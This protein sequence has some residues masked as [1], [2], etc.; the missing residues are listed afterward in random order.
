MSHFEATI[1]SE[2]EKTKAALKQ[3]KER[4]DIVSIQSRERK[5]LDAKED[6]FRNSLRRWFLRVR[7][8]LVPSQVAL[9][10]ASYP[11]LGILLSP[12][13]IDI[14]EDARL[15]GISDLPDVHSM[16]NIFKCLAWSL[17][18]LAIIRRKPSIS[19]ISSLVMMA[20]SFQLPDEKALKTMKFMLNRATQLQSKIVKALN[21]TKSNNVPVLM[22]LEAIA[23]AL[24]L[25]VP[26][27][28][29]LRAA[30]DGD[31][32]LHCVC[33][34]PSHGD[35]MLRCI[36]CDKWFH[37]VSMEESKQSAASFENWTCPL[38]RGSNP[39]PSTTTHE[40]CSKE[41][42][43]QLFET[44]SS[45]DA[46]PHA[47]DPAK[48]WPPFGIL[49]SDVALEVLGREC[50]DIPDETCKLELLSLQ[51][52]TYGT[53]IDT[54]HVISSQPCN[55]GP[56]EQIHSPKSRESSTE[57]QSEVDP[58]TEVDEAVHRLDKSERSGGSLSE[59]SPAANTCGAVK[60][61]SN[62]N[63]FLETDLAPINAMYTK[64][65]ET[66]NEQL[67]TSGSIKEID[68]A[69]TS[70]FQ[71]DEVLS[72]KVEKPLATKTEKRIERLCQPADFATK[73]SL[74]GDG[75]AVEDGSGCRS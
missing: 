50:S 28:R 59:C 63:S 31:G 4:V 33:R 47:P 14:I 38:C 58:F 27:K 21:E 40:F 12:P 34:G 32:A 25:N 18:S 16:V 30:I 15:L 22:E 68:G 73:L 3:A 71:R 60:F 42:T 66:Q 19:E 39:T 37:K 54:R 51:N 11:S 23:D 67:I 7:S 35:L 69:A 72:D 6:E 70:S 1:A 26:E 20:S 13:M 24:P 41:P 49:G 74:V 45:S 75:I 44:C 64:S 43:S 8:L 61:S 29:I 2:L 46:S 57:N 17:S 65:S 56:L 62:E 9:A 52:N 36:I 10:E 55:S 53:V 5:L 48:L